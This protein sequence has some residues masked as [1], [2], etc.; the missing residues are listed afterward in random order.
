METQAALRA[1]T[2]AW[3]PHQKYPRPGCAAEMWVLEEREAA[4]PEPAA[5]GWRRRAGRGHRRESPWC[6]R[7]PGD[8]PDSSRPARHRNGGRERRPVLAL[9]AKVA[10]WTCGAAERRPF[11]GWCEGWCEAGALGWR[12]SG[13]VRHG[14]HSTPE[15]NI[16]PWISLQKCREMA[17]Y[18]RESDCSRSARVGGWAPHRAEGSFTSR[19]AQRR[20]RRG[21]V[22]VNSSGRLPF[23]A[24]G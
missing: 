10:S 17:E 19:S 4:P 7:T 20:A 12:T 9:E 2:L 18:G 1:R 16:L 3:L 15:D 5:R 24:P 8:A 22:T 23:S 14:R 6:R 13:S 21:E 11:R